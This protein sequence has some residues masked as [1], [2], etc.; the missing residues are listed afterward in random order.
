MEGYKIGYFPDQNM[1]NMAIKTDIRRAL[2][3][4]DKR[5]AHRHHTVEANSF[6]SKNRWSNLGPGRR[7]QFSMNFGLKVQTGTA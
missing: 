4:L 1:G 5:S 3:M 2:G 7:L 6:Y